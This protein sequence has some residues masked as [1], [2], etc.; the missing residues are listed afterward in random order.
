MTTTTSQKQAGHTDTA[1]HTDALGLVSLIFDTLILDRWDGGDFDD[2]D[3]RRDCHSQEREWTLLEEL[4]FEDP[5]SDDGR[6]IG[7]RDLELMR[8]QAAALLAD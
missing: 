3:T 6:P 1:G 7:A 2:P 5:A 4:G 8:E